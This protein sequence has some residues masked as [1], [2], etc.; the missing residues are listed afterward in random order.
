MASSAFLVLL[1]ATAAPMGTAVGL[2]AA[3]AGQQRALEA[4]WDK[5]LDGQPLT[6]V[7]SKEVEYTAPVKRVTNLLTKMKA[8]LEKEG[9]DEAEMYD[10]M[11]CWCETSEK[12]KTKA[13]ADAEAKELALEAELNERQA[14]FGTLATDIDQAKVDIAE[15]TEALKTATAVREKGAKEFRGEETD[16]TQA[17]DNVRNAVF[18]LSKHQGGSSLLQLDNNM[19]SGLRV[20]LR[21]TALR[22]EMLLAKTGGRTSRPRQQLAALLQT[23]AKSKA[24]QDLLSALD[25]NGGKVPSEEL[26]INFAQDIVAHAA[27][28]P[29]SATFLQAKD[30]QPLYASYSA[31]SDGIYGILTQ[32][33]EEFEAELKASQK[34]EV[35]AVADFEAL[36][37]A[38][39]KQIETTKA[40][41]DEMEG[42]FAG[43]QKA[44][45]DAQE[46]LEL[47]RNQRSADIKFLQNLQTQCNDLDTEWERRSKTRTE[48]IAAVSEALVILT[49]DDNREHLAETAPGHKPSLASFLQLRSGTEAA[50]RARRVR[51]AAAI[52]RSAAQDPAFD[53]DDLLSM[54]HNRHSRPTVGASSAPRAQ[55]STLAVSVQ[56]DSFTKVKE[57]MD[58]MIAELKKEQE[59]EVKFKAFCRK[60]LDET[61]QTTFK[62]NVHREDLET[63]IAQ[64]AAH[65]E[66]LASEIADAQDQ[67]ASTKTLILKS[68][69]QREKENAEYQTLVADA[70]ATKAILTK[71]LHRL[72]AFYKKAKGGDFLQKAAQTPPVQ[73]NKYKTNDNASPV[74]GLIEQIIQDSDQLE[75]EATKGEY[76][77]QANYETMVNDSTALIA[78]LDAAIY[79]KGKAIAQAKLDTADAQSDLDSTN[80]ELESLAQYDSDLHAQCDFTMKNF[81]IRQKARMQEMEAIGAAKAILSGDTLK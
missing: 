57:M 61:E 59:E 60:E 5:E 42:E 74:I 2:T 55:L 68:S 8:E 38:K 26:P 39:S 62:K 16:L 45:S 25:A 73:F 35:K 53:D 36:A 58:T 77:A 54:W 71:A 34:A 12:E 72:Q 80:G 50:A 70:R 17:I 13:V 44:I 63:K 81:D 14:R 20:L 23:P 29:K 11:V 24:A 65:M 1:L 46:D 3:E 40:K 21:D 27:G 10:K 9:K 18:V 67:I 6:P 15:M 79:A 75:G 43:N 37:A 49:E 66:K 69:Q 52:L 22:Y 28:R 4:A 32:M 76:S 19:L 47:T 7:E 31:R 33:Q 30:G 48:E 51:K 41:L 78:D 64:L 56:L